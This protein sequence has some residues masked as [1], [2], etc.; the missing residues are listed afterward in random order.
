MGARMSGGQ[1]G[2]WTVWCE[3]EGVTFQN[4]IVFQEMLRSMREEKT[5]QGRVA[6]AVSQNRAKAGSIIHV[7]ASKLCPKVA[8]RT[9]SGLPRRLALQ[10]QGPLK[11][12]WE[13][14]T[15][16]ASSSFETQARQSKVPETKDQT[17]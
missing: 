13:R 2:W 10:P 3:L 1:G 15:A 5:V 12:T 11:T 4:V 8:P 9:L 6:Q 14:V 16:H 7:W 17:S